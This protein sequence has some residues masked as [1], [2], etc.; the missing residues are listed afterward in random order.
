[1]PDQ[2][3]A[4]KT[5]DKTRRGGL[6]VPTEHTRLVATG[7]AALAGGAGRRSTPRRYAARSAFV[8][9]SAGGFTPA[10]TKPGERSS[11]KRTTAVETELIERVRANPEIARLIVAESRNIQAEAVAAQ[12]EARHRELAH[13]SRETSTTG[14]YQ[15]GRIISRDTE[16]A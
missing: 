11:D 10:A 8:R 6:P 4:D 12:L 5:R 3:R 14:S 9:L 7:T 13:A 16:A 15:A 1:M 2:R